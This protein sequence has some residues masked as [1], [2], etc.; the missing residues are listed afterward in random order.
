MTR[1]GVAVV[2]GL[3]AIGAG[4]AACS[5]ER[6]PT[7]AGSGSPNGGPGTISPG[8][9]GAVTANLILESG[10]NLT[11]LSWTINGP[12]TYTGTIP[13]GDA[14][15]VEVV[16]GGI[17]AG[18]G[19]TITLSGSD[20]AGDVC[21]GTSNAFTVAPGVVSS[22]TLL[23]IC[24]EP[25]D[26]SLAADVTTG[27][28]EV[29]ASVTV[30]QAPP[31]QCP[32]ITSFSISP[33]EVVVGQPAQLGLAATQPSAIQWTVN[34]PTG[35]TFVNPAD[36]GPGAQTPNAQFQCGAG[37]NTTVTVTATVSLFDSGACAGQQFTSMSGQI[38]CEAACAVAS[39]CPGSGT[40]CEPVACIAGGC[41]LQSA[42]E[43]IT[44]DAGA[45]CNGQGSCEAFTFS[46]LRIFSA[47]G[48]AIPPSGSGSELASPVAIQERLV[49]DGGIVGTVF[50][51][52]SSSGSQDMLTLP[53]GAPVAGLA[54]SA[55]GHY[56]SMAGYNASVGVSDPSQ[57]E[58]TR[59]VARIA[60]DGGVDTST[61]FASGIAFTSPALLR[62]SVSVDGAE[63]WVSGSGGTIADGGSSSGIWYV[64]F[65]VVG[66]VQLTN[67]PTRLLDIA[68][69][70]LYASG[71]ANVD[72][73]E[74]ATVGSGLPTV[75][76]P[77]VTVL[78]GLPTVNDAGVSP[79][80]FVFFQL[81]PASTGPDT[82]YV[83]DDRV[84]PSGGVMGVQRLSLGDGGS[85]AQSAVLTLSAADGGAP[86]GF[87]G[88][89][90]IQTGP[91]QVTLIA[92]TI[93]TP[94]RIAVFTDDGVTSPWNGTSRVIA[95]ANAGLESFRGVALSPHP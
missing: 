58:D 55:D 23:V 68:D 64:P 24:T 72:A 67:K 34:P 60:P 61:Q 38:H 22:V 40:V 92:T 5:S 57:S 66:G 12:H 79:Y 13:I 4:F 35:G 41:G 43:G 31:P 52:T 33:A 21:L 65:G 59:V 93:E 36:G 50:L 27:S 9:A 45:I 20:S 89:A 75:G 16:A 84:L 17:L 56:L 49:S 18:S 32:G 10:A 71:E 2:V 80:Q 14:Q 76:S 95:V 26:S 28:V 86:T 85:W 53:A 83:A 46:V 51:P 62:G 7:S 3:T 42:P 88:L 54:R 69:G 15:S 6:G 29:D 37:G 91:D 8:A 78:P 39:D 94:T 82:L 1:L 81:N 30:V 25:T 77:T 70:Q 73:G 11:S 47:D 90:G 74:V 44:C 87:R 48:G 63:F 19:Y